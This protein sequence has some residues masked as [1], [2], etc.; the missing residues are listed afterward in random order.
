MIINKSYLRLLD[1]T[2][3]VGD[4]LGVDSLV[5]WA[6]E[7]GC[8]LRLVATSGTGEP[9]PLD[10]ETTTG[11]AD[12]LQLAL[13]T[14]RP[15]QLEAL[16]VFA[17][18]NPEMLA[19]A[20]WETRQQLI[21]HEDKRRCPECKKEGERSTVRWRAGRGTDAGW[22][23]YYDEAGV[24]H[25]HNPNSVKY[26]MSCSCGHKWTHTVRYRCPTRGCSWNDRETP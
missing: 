21:D 10:T 4:A 12:H 25:S 13:R 5:E 9:A 16:A 3:S 23:P 1:N 20:A 2:I 6:E 26:P 22:E 18:H 14:L 11:H 8:E 15:R 7:N 24:Y 19:T 17:K